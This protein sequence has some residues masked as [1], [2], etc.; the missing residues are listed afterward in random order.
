MSWTGGQRMHNL[1]MAAAPVTTDDLTQQAWFFILYTFCYGLG[2]AS[3]SW[4][5]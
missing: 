4:K 3:M 5:K 2:R 1:L